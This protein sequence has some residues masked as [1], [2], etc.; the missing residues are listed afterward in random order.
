VA[1]DAVALC[2]YREWLWIEPL[3]EVPQLPEAGEALRW[4][5]QARL[6][7]AGGWLSFAS[8]SADHPAAI[9]EAALRAGELRVGPLASSL[10]V[11]LRP[12]GPSRSLKHWHQALGV[13]ARLRAGLPGVRLAGRLVH[14]AGLGE[15]WERGGVEE[16]K[17]AGAPGAAGEHGEPG[18]TG[19]QGPWWRLWWEPAEASDPRHALCALQQ[20]QVG[21]V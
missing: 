12:G 2:R 19:S 9:A 20:S 11:R 18:T 14:A 17:D 13:P 21:R 6:P 5:G 7:A 10:R 8:V 16:G 1:L 4:A 3:G 15:V